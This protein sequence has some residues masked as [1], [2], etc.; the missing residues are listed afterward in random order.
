[1]SRSHHV[2]VAALVAVAAAIDLGDLH[3]FGFRLS[4]LAVVLAA[5]VTLGVSL[6]W[7]RTR[8]AAALAVA[9]LGYLVAW[10]GFVLMPEPRLVPTM[11]Q[12]AVWVVVFGQIAEGTDRM[13]VAAVGVLG[14]CVALDALQSLRFVGESDAP[15]TMLLFNAMTSTFVP[16]V[17]CAAAYAVRGRLQLATARAAQA[18]RL[19]E[20]DAR[21]A[22]HA[23]R[24]R[25][26]RELHDVVANRLSAVAMRITAAGHVRRSAVTPEGE[27]LDEIGREIDTA[28]GE[29]RSM[30]GTLRSDGSGT[31]TAPPPSLAHV[32]ELA[33]R[34][35]AEVEVVVEGVAVRLPSVVDLAAYR[36]VQEA[37][38]NV[39]R[40]ARP[41][42]AVVTVGYREDGVHLR[43]DDEGASTEASGTPAGHGI[44]GMRERAALCGGWAGA[45]AR[46]GGGWTVEAV[47]PLREPAPHPETPTPLA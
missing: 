5:G 9:G 43:V 14:G 26:A 31:P 17:L 8:P 32:E 28:L 45:G 25:L 18:E 46:A 34:C 2:T 12:A 23:E 3:W 36:I 4:W 20:L 6:V 40:H 35:G 41:A 29:L 33:L 21:S 11:A 15:L 19:R 42:R 47:L 1:M 37:L 13:R 30:L 16:L 44:I 10:T 22:A 7:H 39:S 24:V 38:A 27:V